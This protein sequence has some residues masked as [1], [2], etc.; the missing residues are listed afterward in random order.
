M[1]TIKTQSE[2][3]IIADGGH[4]LRQVMDML[5][6]AAKPGIRGEQLE[7]LTR[8]A[9]LNFGGKPA[10]LNYS[11]D[12]E[13]APFPAALCLSLNGTVVHGIPKN[14]GALKNG[15]L[16]KLDIGMQFKGLFTDMARTIVIGNSTAEQK[17]LIVAAKEAFLAGLKMAKEGNTLGD[18]GFAIESRIQAHHFFVIK[19]LTGHGLGY[20]P[21]EDPWV[22]NYGNPGKGLKLKSGMVLAI[23]PMPDAGTSEIIE[24]RDG[25]FVTADGSLA[26]HYENT[27]VVTPTGGKILTK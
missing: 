9:I 13:G 11:P 2:I 21:H 22:L 26:S 3:K 19:E 10:F 7:T 4:R 25:S 12:P 8:S 27:L 24:R 16:V 1:V 18:V 5:I 17:E 14:T 23:E 6:A 15:D 20:R